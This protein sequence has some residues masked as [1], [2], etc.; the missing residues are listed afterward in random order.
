ME[1]WKDENEPIE[2]FLKMFDECAKIEDIAAGLKKVNQLIWFDYTQ[3]GP[4][5]SFWVDCRGG[6][7]KA[8]QGKPD[9][10]PNLTM[11]LSVD[12]AHRAWSN[13]L[14]P[15]MAITRRKIKVKGSATGLLKLV[16]KSKKTAEVYVQ[17]LRDMGK[18]DIIL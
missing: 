1:F 11:S 16:P 10:E 18:E 15:V 8:G 6:E 2:A 14:N 4:N 7:I 17:V 3:D 9:E 13:K 5:C 12:D